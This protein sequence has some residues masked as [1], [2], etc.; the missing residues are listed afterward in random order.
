MLLA[1]GSLHPEGNVFEHTMLVLDQ[2]AKVRD[3]ADDPYAFML[4]ALCHDYGKA[5]TTFFNEKK[6]RLVAYGHDNAAKPLVNAFM[7]RLR[8]PTAVRAYVQN[9]T[10]LHMQPKKYVGNNAT[11][12]AFNNMFDKTK[13]AEDI[14]LLARCDHFGRGV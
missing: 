7:D 9:L 5:T 3:R 14:L 6:Q 2:A 10:A 8:L 11:D 13:H 4:T 1:T 12:F